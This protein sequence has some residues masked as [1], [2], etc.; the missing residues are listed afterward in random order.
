M[1]KS[2]FSMSTETGTTQKLRKP[3][4]PCKYWL[5]SKSSISQLWILQKRSNLS[6]HAYN[7][8][9]SY[10]T[11]LGFIPSSTARRSGVGF[12]K[13]LIHTCHESKP[14]RRKMRSDIYWFA[15][16]CNSQCLSHFA[17][18]FI[19][20]RAEVSI[21]KG[22]FWEVEDMTSALPIVVKPTSASAVIVM[23]VISTFIQSN[24][25]NCITSFRHTM[26]A[27]LTLLEGVRPFGHL[28]WP[29]P[30]CVNLILLCLLPIYNATTEKRTTHSQQI[31]TAGFTGRE[32]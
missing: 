10:R 18:S 11:K 6:V 2:R 25:T 21:V 27:E 5:L 23:F 4:N 20:S 31:H 30:A 16:I 15:E 7:D 22:M 28:E 8:E 19:A 1:V 32:H 12:I 26:V 24:L 14:P 13:T 3:L 9:S 29:N 17:A